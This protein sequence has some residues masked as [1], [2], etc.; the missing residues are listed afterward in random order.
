MAH[1]NGQSCFPNTAIS[2]HNKLVE[3]HL[4]CHAVVVSLTDCW[5]ISFTGSRAARTVGLEFF[6]NRWASTKDMGGLVEVSS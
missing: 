6:S 5:A 1:L 2:Q 4:P 3:S